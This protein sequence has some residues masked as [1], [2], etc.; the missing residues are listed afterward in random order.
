MSGETTRRNEGKGDE[1]SIECEMA[2]RGGNDLIWLEIPREKGFFERAG[3][4]G[5]HANSVY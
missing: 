1:V 3:K 4:D 2:R 5:K